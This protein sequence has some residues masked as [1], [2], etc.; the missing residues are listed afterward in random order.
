MVEAAAV[1]AA[2]AAAAAGAVEDAPAAVAGAAA[3]GAAAPELTGAAAVAAGLGVAL[4]I[5]DDK[6]A[7]AWEAGVGDSEEIAVE[8]PTSDPP[9]DCA[10]PVS[11]DDGPVPLVT[12]PAVTPELPM[13]DGAAMPSAPPGPPPDTPA[14]PP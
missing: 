14:G 3:V 12:S 5:G 2:P 13:E 8:L 10:S 6:P 1:A 11:E 9:D 4:G 7:G